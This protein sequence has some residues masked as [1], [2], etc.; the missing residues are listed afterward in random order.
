VD[1]VSDKHESLSI[2]TLKDW[3]IY[4]PK[5]APALSV[6]IVQNHKPV[7]SVL[8]NRGTHDVLVNGTG[9]SISAV[10]SK[11][12]HNGNFDSINFTDSSGISYRVHKQGNEW[13]LARLP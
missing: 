10:I 3:E 1:P 6:M 8:S 5:D 13:V 11:I 4:Q 7:A 2:T 12:D 9:G